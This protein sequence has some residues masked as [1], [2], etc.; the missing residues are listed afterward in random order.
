MRPLQLSF[1][2]IRSYPGAVGPLDFTGKTLI[3]I[4]GDTIPKNVAVFMLQ[5]IPKQPSTKPSI[6]LPES[7]RNTEA[8]L[9]L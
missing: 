2:G 4:I 8:G 6:R 5:M 1:S 7:P 3:A 9:K